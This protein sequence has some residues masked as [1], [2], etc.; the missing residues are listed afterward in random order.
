MGSPTTFPHC[1]GRE[2]VP[3]LAWIDDITLLANS[4]HE[5]QQMLD[6]LLSCLHARSLHI[7]ATKAQFIT[8]RWVAGATLRVHDTVHTASESMVVL[9]ITLRGDGT[10]QS[11][12]EDSMS[13][14][15]ATYRSH[16]GTL[17][18]RHVSLRAKLRHWQVTVA[19]AALWGWE[20][21]PITQGCLRR[22]DSMQLRHIAWIAGHRLTGADDMA[23]KWQQAIRHARRLMHEC[24][25]KPLSMQILHRYH[26]WAG[27]TCRASSLGYRLL[28]WR[29]E[30]WR[31]THMHQYSLSARQ[32]R[33]RAGQPILWER[34]L[35]DTI[36]RH[37]HDETTERDA[38]R[39]S[40]NE[41]VTKV[42]ARRRLGFAAAQGMH[43]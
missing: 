39:A 36:G 31:I 42:M 7:K 43:M 15:A 21:F 6:D 2:I 29:N 38:W 41:W 3:I 37:W 28:Q 18:G 23:S 33:A 19:A 4:M 1:E 8:G 13:K 27:H 12:I 9:G 32:L 40:G 10:A 22:L 35:L 34:Q 16:R 14:A 26:S 5:A 24:G 11:H 17:F 25:I 30:E 20:V